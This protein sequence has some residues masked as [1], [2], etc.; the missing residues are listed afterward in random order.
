LPE[1]V[2][3]VLRDP[4]TGS[5]YGEATARLEGGVYRVEGDWKGREWVILDPYPGDPPTATLLGALLVESVAVIGYGVYCYGRQ[6]FLEASRLFPHGVTAAPR[7]YGLRARIYLEL[8]QSTWPPYYKVD[9]VRA[10]AEAVRRSR[11]LW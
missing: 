11:R 9:S 1:A 3:G 5:V 4:Y 2:S 8:D 6:S 7:G 10:V